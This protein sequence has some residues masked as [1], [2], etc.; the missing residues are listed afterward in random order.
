MKAGIYL[1]KQDV[2]VVEKDIPQIGEHDVLIQN[3]YSSICGTDVAVYNHGPATGHKISV[4]SE[5]GHETISRVVRIGKDVTEFEL[6]Q[7]VY[8]YPLLVTGDKSRAGHIGGFSEYI[9]AKNAKIN[10]TLY[11]IPDSISSKEASLIEPFTVGCKAA[12]S[13]YPKEGKKAIVFGAGTI[14]IAAAITL[15]YYGCK[16]VMVCDLS[17][18]RLNIIENLGFDTCNSTKEDPI[19]KAKNLYGTA[20]SLKGQTADIDIWIDAAGAESILNLFME[21]GKVGSD[22]S[23]VAVNKALREID[24]LDLT[25][26]SKS[27]HGSGG[28][29]PDDVKDVLNIMASHKWDIESIITHEFS[30]DDLDK[31]IQQASKSEEALNVVIKF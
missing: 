27:I 11:P 16:Q 23:I 24:L 28:Y 18:Y 29:G 5:F 2:K 7:R 9:L 15:K 17:D 19:E 8:P 10:Q 22:Y 26:S 4:G 14:G 30:I 13:A 6:G 12:K 25:Y 3:I 20:Y 21:K 31:A 1:G